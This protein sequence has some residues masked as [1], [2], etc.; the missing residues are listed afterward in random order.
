MKTGGRFWTKRA[1]WRRSTY[2]RYSNNKAILAVYC[3]VGIEIARR[4][5]NYSVYDVAIGE[6]KGAEERIG[7]PDISRMVARFEAQL[8][9]REL[10]GDTD[11]D[12]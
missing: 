2:R 12:L 9:G 4:T 11:D 10:E 5:G 7:D 1:L 8:K 6:L 3:E